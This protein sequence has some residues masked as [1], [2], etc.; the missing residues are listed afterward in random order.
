VR[1]R[2]APWIVGWLVLVGGCAKTIESPPALATVEGPCDAVEYL[3]F[4]EPP[5]ELEVTVTVD[6]RGRARR[7]EPTR[8][9]GLAPAQ[10]AR[11]LD[12]VRHAFHCRNRL[13][14]DA[15]RSYPGYRLRFVNHATLPAIDSERC[16]RAAR[17]PRGAASFG[18]RGNASVGLTLDERGHVEQAWV[19]RAGPG[20][21]AE[22]AIDALVHRCSFTPAV[23]NDQPMPYYLVY[24]F[25]FRMWTAGEAAFYRRRP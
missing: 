2:H 4:G 25:V 14:S 6:D 10:V 8:T 9:A 24:R 16:G 15:P 12:I 18:V 23:W 5:G 13:R 20:G 1:D 17:Y 11:G 21:F 3:A 22:S 19:D 7:V